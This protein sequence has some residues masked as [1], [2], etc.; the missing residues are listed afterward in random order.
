MIIQNNAVDLTNVNLLVDD[1][2]GVAASFLNHLTETNAKRLVDGYNLIAISDPDNSLAPIITEILISESTEITLKKETMLS[3]ILNNIIATLRKASV[4]INE[5]MVTI[6]DFDTIYNI[7]NMFTI[8]DGVEDLMGISIILEN[9]SITALERFI[10][11]YG[12]VYMVEEEVFL[13]PL[14]GLIKDVSEVTVETIKLSLILPEINDIIPDKLISRIKANKDLINTTFVGDYI[15]ADGNIGLPVESLL[16]FFKPELTL[17]RGQEDEFP[18]HYYN[19]VAAI[20][21]ISDVNNESL[22]SELISRIRDSVE[23]LDLIF[24]IDNLIS[25]VK[26]E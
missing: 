12:M 15:R 5:D 8:V 13:E 7:L 23:D 9:Q 25:K 2:G 21:I 20:I 19:A 10:K 3:L 22:Q 1:V 6:N 11:C 24:D 18:M 4:Y 14:Y 26:Y 17:L 16:G